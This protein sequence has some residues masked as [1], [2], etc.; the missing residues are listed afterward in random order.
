V[1]GGIYPTVENILSQNDEAQGTEMYGQD[2][3]LGILPV[4][5]SIGKR[6]N[7]VSHSPG[8]ISSF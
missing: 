7:F 4:E 1:Q 8:D 3:V 2:K 5:H 6:S